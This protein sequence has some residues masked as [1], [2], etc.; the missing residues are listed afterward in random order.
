MQC[1]SCYAIA[2]F[3]LAIQNHHYDQSDLIHKCLGIC[4]AEYSPKVTLTDNPKKNLER[5]IAV[6]HMEIIR[7]LQ[8]F[9]IPTENLE[10]SIGIHYL[11]TTRRD[12]STLQKSPCIRCSQ[13]VKGNWSFSTHVS[14]VNL[15]MYPAPCQC[16]CCYCGVKSNPKNFYEY[17]N[18]CVDVVKMYENVIKTLQLA[19][20]IGLVLPQQTP[21]QISSGEITIHPYKKEILGLVRGERAWFFTNCFIFDEEIAKELHDNPL[22]AIDIS[23]DAGTPETWRK[24]KGVNNFYHVLDN[25]KTYKKAS[26]RAEQITLKYI[27][28]PGLNDSEEDFLSFVNIAKALDVQFFRLARDFRETPDFCS[29]DNMSWE[30]SKTVESAS[31]LSAICQLNGITPILY[32]E[33][34]LSEYEINCINFLADKLLQHMR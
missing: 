27:V 9:P 31:R 2:K 24:I 5:L 28:I 30:F 14:Y 15:S 1:Y 4:C 7:G 22:A 25:L 8:N 20:K 6:R 16:N 3:A 32:S 11:E 21:W 12:N 19:K 29:K 26:Q 17:W 23:I 18:K 33:S 10:Q 34:G 13:Y